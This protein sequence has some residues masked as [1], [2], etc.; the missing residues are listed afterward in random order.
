MFLYI[1]SLVI[2]LTCIIIIIPF[3][4]AFLFIKDSY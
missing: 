4:N 3:A 1:S 2:V